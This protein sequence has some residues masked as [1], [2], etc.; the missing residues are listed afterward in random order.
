VISASV[1]RPLTERVVI[2]KLVSQVATAVQVDTCARWR[3]GFSHSARQVALQAA[4]HGSACALHGGPIQY[5]IDI[6]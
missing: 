3:S 4:A 5:P 6:A 1:E 2:G